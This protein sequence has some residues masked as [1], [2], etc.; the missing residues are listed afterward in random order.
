MSEERSRKLQ[1]SSADALPERADEAVLPRAQDSLPSRRNV[2]PERTLE[3]P[4]QTRPD[5]SDLPE[6]IDRRS[7]CSMLGEDMA[8]P[9][10]PHKAGSHRPQ[11]TIIIPEAKQPD[12]SDDPEHCDECVSS[13]GLLLAGG[14]D[15][16]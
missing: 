2:R 11:V 8:R 13:P 15:C 7:P 3:I 10:M 1:K 5:P 9:P 4:S 6:H 12:P 14:E 16:E